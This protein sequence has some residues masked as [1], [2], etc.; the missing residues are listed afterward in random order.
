MLRRTLGGALVMAGLLAISGCGKTNLH[1]PRRPGELSTAERIDDLCFDLA[2]QLKAENYQAVESGRPPVGERG[3]QEA[4]SIGE[5][6]SLEQGA[7]KTRR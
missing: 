6:Y 2:S 3:T 7:L 4:I 5:K 1:P